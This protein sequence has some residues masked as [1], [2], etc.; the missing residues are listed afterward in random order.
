MIEFTTPHTSKSGRR[1]A[2]V[3]KYDR[4]P[5]NNVPAGIET[6]QST[7]QIGGVKRTRR[8]TGKGCMNAMKQGN[9]A[10]F[11]SDVSQQDTEV[12][13]TAVQRWCKS[14]GRGKNAQKQRPAMQRRFSIYRTEES[15]CLYSDASG[16]VVCCVWAVVKPE[17]WSACFPSWRL[18]S[19]AFSLSS[20]VLLKSW[21]AI[22]RAYPSWSKVK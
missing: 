9:G 7:P 20:E 10:V 11:H 18:L 2:S 19:L 12:V 15:V 4:L 16:F 21:S 3:Q 8:E 1:S 22:L 5:T 6:S 14:T 17:L 13:F